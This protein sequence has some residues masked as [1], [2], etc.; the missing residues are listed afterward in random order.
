MNL[1]KHKAVMII[2][3][4]IVLIGISFSAVALSSPKAPDVSSGNFK[5]LYADRLEINV[6]NTDFEIIKSSDEAQTVTITSIITLKKTQADFYGILN[7]LTFSGIAYDS[8]LFTS[9]NSVT[10]G[11]TPF[12]MTL[13]ASDKAPDTYKWQMDVTFSVKGNGNYPA[14]L[15]LDYTTGYTKDTAQQKLLEI[16]FSI[17]VK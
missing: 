8:L 9:L 15:T 13:G 17:I 3:S 10:E 14:T 12:D 5:N 2:I 1:K 6:E 7:S 4:V 11:K 16:P